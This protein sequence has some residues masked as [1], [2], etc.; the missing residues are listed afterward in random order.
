MYLA[1][2]VNIFHLVE[3]VTS[4]TIKVSV[5]FGFFTV[6]YKEFDLC[7]IANQIDITCPLKSGTYNRT[8]TETL[9][10]NV[11]SVSDYMRAV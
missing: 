3:E 4:G 9:Q 1:G 6:Y 10:H 8:I 7:D 5:Q 2:R 11:P